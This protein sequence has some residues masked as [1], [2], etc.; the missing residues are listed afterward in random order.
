MFK[1]FG[2]LLFAFV[3]LVIYLPGNGFSQEETKTSLVMKP[4]HI[5]AFK[6]GVSIVRA[7]VELSSAEGSF[8]IHPLPD[9]SLGSFWL[10]WDQGIN[11]TNITATQAKTSKTVTASSIHELLEANIGKSVYLKLDDETFR[12][13]WSNFIIKDIPKPPES[14]VI[15]PKREDILPPPLPNQGHIVILEI[16]ERSGLNATAGPNMKTVIVPVSDIISVMFDDDSSYSLEHHTVE[17]VIEFDVS[18]KEGAT[19]DKPKVWVTYL[20]NGIA[21]SPSY[22]IDISDDDKALF[23]AKSVIMNDLLPLE[24]VET[25]LIAGYPHLQFSGKASAFSLN[26]IQQIMEKMGRG[27][28][29]EEFANNMFYAGAQVRMSA[30]MSRP[31]MPDTAVGGEQTEDL[32]FYQLDNITLKKGERGY[33]P[34][35]ANSINYEHL[36][37]WNIPNYIDN[38]NNYRFD[39]VE[40][41]QEIWHSIKLTNSSNQPWTSAPAMVMKDN[42]VL[43]QDTLLYTAPSVETN[44]KITQALDIQAEVNE[45]ETNRQRN[46]YEQQ[47][48]NYDLVT[49]KGTIAITNYKSETV[50]LEISKVL[51]GDVVSADGDP[52]I[53]KL[54]EGLRSVNSTS[55]LKWNLEI[56]PGVDNKQVFEYS[57]TVYVQG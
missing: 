18:K 31:S 10:S 33:F 39:L 1:H 16:T 32:Y 15:Y 7:E 53:N 37:T 28:V 9:A 19:T 43:G 35:F 14:N 38:N 44:L 2:I 4:Y 24:D 11:L 29:Q 50:T 46:A 42:R 20:A 40:A 36:Y 13:G 52:E 22:V 51:S 49:V 17:N 34:M 23:S 26:P 21:W 56:K 3:S 5:A 47:R 41:P 27:R 25:E 12:N 54:A 48:R 57:Y 30:D 45:F 8:R 6:N 55:E